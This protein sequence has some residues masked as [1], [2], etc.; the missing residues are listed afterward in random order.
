MSNT[1][2]EEFGHRGKTQPRDRWRTPVVQPRPMPVHGLAMVLR[3][4]RSVW[5]AA[6]ERPLLMSTAR[7]GWVAIPLFM[8]RL[9][10]RCR[11][12]FQVQA[13]LHLLAHVLVCAP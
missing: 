11:S 4:I 3:P 10:V 6:A 9:P 7:H 13:D 2:V 1:K 8:L 12:R 5:L